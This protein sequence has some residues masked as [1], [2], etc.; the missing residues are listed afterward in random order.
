MNAGSE[1]NDANA[2][3]AFHIAAIDF[4]APDA[5][6]QL[7]TSLRTSGFA[8]LKTHPIDW[9]LVD[10][11]YK[12]WRSFLQKCAA[13]AEKENG[14]PND[15]SAEALYA[16]YLFDA[17]KQDG[18]F[19]M[20]VS[21]KA[22]G[23]KVKDIKHYYQCYFPWG[24]Y[25]E[26]VTG[27][28]RQLFEQTTSLGSKLLEWI[29]A[30]IR[31]TLP[32]VAK[33]LDEK[34]KCSMSEAIGLEQTML[35]V[36]HYPAYDESAIEPGAIRAAAHED[37]NFITVLP[38][39]SARGLEVWNKADQ[40]WCQVPV[41]NQCIII[42][43]GDMLQELTDHAYVSTTH[44]VVKPADAGSEVGDRLSVPTFIHARPDTFLS[45]QYPR[46]R[47]YLEERLRQLGV[48]K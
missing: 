7:T 16:K 48:L 35:R 29:E 44:R 8:V 5:A 37:I 24:R 9:K 26:E 15:S 27:G 33:K 20:S 25:P 39:G 42:N 43:V 19:P 23:A 34:L 2:T 4:D 6:R 22:K 14:K 36:L 10:D 18:Y 47:L 38:S 45:E 21:E 13:G 30:D 11:L 17:E 41:E 1:G 32:K 40:K 28:A 46:A 12:E 3:S 31:Q